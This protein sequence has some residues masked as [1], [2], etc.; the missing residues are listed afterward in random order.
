MLLLA[1]T[2]RTEFDFAHSAGDALAAIMN[3]PASALAARDDDAG[4]VTST[5]TEGMSRRHDRCVSCG[6]GWKGMVYDRPAPKY[7]ASDPAGYRAEQILSS[8]L[9]RLY[10]ALGGDAGRPVSDDAAAE[11]IR[12]SAA[13]YV[14]YLIVRAIRALSPAEAVPTNDAVIFAAA[15]QNADIGT[16]KFN[17]ASAEYGG[18]KNRTKQVGR[19]CAQDRALGVR[20]AGAL[21][22]A[23]GGLRNMPGDAPRVDVFLDDRAGRNGGYDWAD[24]WDASD[25]TL[26]WHA[27]DDAVRIEHEPGVPGKPEQPRKAEP[28]RKA[29]QAQQSGDLGNL[30]N[31]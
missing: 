15:L 10:R 18:S 29:K 8:T 19:R 25:G 6:W 14:T 22:P 2:D 30:S 13:Y 9:F 5:F 12:W 17:F 31:H 26:W 24:K 4:G 23:G 16:G 27:S 7:N 3:D 1:A 20:A 21:F 28:A 11:K